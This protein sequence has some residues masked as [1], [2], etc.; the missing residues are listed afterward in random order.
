MASAAARSMCRCSIE[1]GVFEVLA[2]AGDT[3]PGGE[4]FG[5]HAMEHFVKVYKAKTGT[6]PSK[7]QRE[8]GMPKQG[9]RGRKALAIDTA[10][11][12]HRD[13]EL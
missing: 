1:D 8:M 3:H 4:D 5:S 13:R 7:N 10:D 6:N 12:G 11:R 9:G 2:T